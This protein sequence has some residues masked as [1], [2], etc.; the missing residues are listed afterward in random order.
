MWRILNGFLG[1]FVM[2]GIAFAFSF[3]RKKV[4]WRI[5]LTGT[6]MQFVFAALILKTSGGRAFFKLF[7]DIVLKILSF[8][9]QGAAFIFGNLVSDFKIGAIFAFKVLPTI[10]FFSSLISVLY[11]LGV[12]QQI[13]KVFAVL[14]MK[15][16]GTSGAE[17]LSCSANIFVGQT[18]APLLIKPYV[19]TMTQS[20]ILTIMTGGFATVAGGVMAAYV[21]M[22]SRTFPSIAGHLLSASIMNAP[23]AIL[24]SKIILPEEEEPLTKGEVKV[25]LPI[26]DANIVDAAANG[27]GQGLQLALNVGAML[28]AFIALI[29]MLNAAFAGVGNGIEMLSNKGPSTFEVKDIKN[30]DS[31]V[32]RMKDPQTEIAKFVQSKLSPETMEK[33]EKFT[34]KPDEAKVLKKSIVTDLN[35]IIDSGTSIYNEQLFAGVSLSPETKKLLETKEKPGTKAHIAKENTTRLNHLLLVE[36]FPGDINKRLKLYRRRYVFDLE[37]LFGWIF[38]PI[39]FV[40]GVPWKD[41]VVIGGLLG[42][43]LVINE[44]VTYADLA[45]ILQQGTIHLDPKSIVIATY[46]MCGFANFSSIAIQIGGIGGIAPSRRS[47]LARLGIY[48]VIAGTL[49][50]FQSASI[51]GMMA[52]G[53]NLQVNMPK[54]KETK[55]AETEEVKENG[56]RTDFNKFVAAKMGVSTE[57]VKETKSFKREV[58]HD[59]RI[60]GCVNEGLGNTG[61]A[62][63]QLSVRELSEK[64]KK[65][66]T[67]HK[68]KDTPV[69][70]GLSPG[71]RS[72]VNKEFLVVY[73]PH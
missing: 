32:L 73:V 57:S 34:G 23:C 1:I 55:P 60:T 69:R 56:L 39:A 30:L 8:S 52:S 7:N 2:I 62:L 24:M 3:N 40:M 51:A 48:G 31:F 53:N 58:R 65:T 45:T 54:E 61:L 15:L 6:A 50:C 16:L 28:M 59:M 20:E 18:E 63:N 66:G 29:A 38:A 70:T 68:G 22:L 19:E 11:Y 36:A 5:V 46:A 49:A 67:A 43:R 47:D 25:D 10:I 35:S 42:K 37:T 4:N 12:M 33:L 41:C 17:T 13:V 71:D 64:I 9:D 27:A 44:F 26:T 72:T 21:G 14:M